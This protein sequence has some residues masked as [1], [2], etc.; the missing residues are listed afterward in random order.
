[1]SML[2]FALVALAAL[3]KDPVTQPPSAPTVQDEQD[4]QDEQETATEDSSAE[5]ATDPVDEEP[6]PES[7]PPQWTGAVTL[8]SSVS[9][10]NTDIKKSTLTADAIKKLEKSRY[11]LGL[12]WNFSEEDDEISQRRIFGSGQF[13]RFVTD[14]LYWLAQ[15]SGESDKNASVD[16]RTTMGGG[17][18]YQFLENE[19]WKLSGE[20]GVSYFD[21]RFANDEDSDYVALR[22]AYKVDWTP[23]SRWSLAQAIQ[24]FL[25]L[26][27]ADDIYA[28]ADTR[29]KV[30]LSGTLFAQLQWIYDWDNTPASGKERVDNLYLLTI[31]WTF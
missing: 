23:N 19:K 10:G 15:L 3:A 2:T 21:E 1:M 18:G 26:E 20:V 7:E 28:K 30:T 22:T 31:G 12:I 25:S 11:T 24:L 14:R 5:A 27:D 9:G 8:G 4:E 17:I 16:L 13:D 6:E 29:L